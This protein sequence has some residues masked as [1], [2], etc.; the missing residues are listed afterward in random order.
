MTLTP[1]GVS[2]VTMVEANKLVSIQDQDERIV[3]LEEF[4]VTAGFQIKT[5]TSDIAALKAGRPLA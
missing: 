2:T 1:T 5:L 3:D 4:E